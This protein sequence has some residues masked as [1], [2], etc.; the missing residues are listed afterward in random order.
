MDIRSNLIVLLAL[1]SVG[2]GFVNGARPLHKMIRPRSRPRSHGSPHFFSI[3]VLQNGVTALL[4]HE[5]EPPRLRHGARCLSWAPFNGAAF[6]DGNEA[7][8]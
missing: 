4:F 7:D 2:V 8:N 1:M 3:S 5:N 6:F